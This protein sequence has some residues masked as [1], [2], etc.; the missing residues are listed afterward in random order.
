[1]ARDYTGQGYIFG[2]ERVEEL[3]AKLRARVRR[4]R[5]D[6][7]AD[8]LASDMPLDDIAARMGITHRQAADYLDDIAR[9]LGPQAV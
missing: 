6:A 7:F 3:K 9:R 1:M 2:G 8:M 4:N 5:L